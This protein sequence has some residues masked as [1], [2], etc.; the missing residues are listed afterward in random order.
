[1]GKKHHNFCLLEEN[2]N[3]IFMFLKGILRAME[4]M[5]VQKV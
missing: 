2:Q 5:Q 4:A 1:M 3:D